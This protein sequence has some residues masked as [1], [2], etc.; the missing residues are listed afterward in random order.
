M[1]YIFFCPVFE[2]IEVKYCPEHFQ[3]IMG[4]K[5]FIIDCNFNR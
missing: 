3:E 2:V 5:L 1:L 4:H